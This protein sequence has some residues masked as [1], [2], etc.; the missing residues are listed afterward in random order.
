MWFLPSWTRQGHE[1]EKPHHARMAK[2]KPCPVVLP[3]PHCHRTNIPPEGN[4]WH[5]PE[6]YRQDPPGTLSPDG[7]RVGRRTCDA[8][9]CA[10]LFEHASEVQCG[11]CDRPVE[12]EIGD[13]HS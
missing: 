13:P 7:H 2:P 3:I 10:P 12:R 9:S 1:K 4:L 8:G 6:R 11:Q 5:A